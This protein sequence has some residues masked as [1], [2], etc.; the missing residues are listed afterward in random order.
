AAGRRGGRPFV[1]RSEARRDNATGRAP[2]D[3]GSDRDLAADDCVRRKMKSAA[4]PAFGAGL[5]P[6][7][8]A[9]AISFITPA[10]PPRWRRPETFGRKNQPARGIFDG[11]QDARAS[12]LGRL[13]KW[14]NV[15]DRIASM[16]RGQ[17]SA[18]SEGG[19]VP[20]SSA[21]RASH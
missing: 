20:R 9:E 3:P 8:L 16:G 13:A 7:A 21:L 10:P 18:I 11:N 17:D 1:Q 2:R 15:L 14:A 4:R 5:F 6:S 12:G 19:T